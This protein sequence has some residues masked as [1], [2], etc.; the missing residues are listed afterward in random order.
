MEMIF[1]FF[2]EK[3]PRLKLLVKLREASYYKLTKI[4]TTITLKI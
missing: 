3:R 1:A 2:V 4:R